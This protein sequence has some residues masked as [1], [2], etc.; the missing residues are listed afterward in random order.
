M[1]TCK[2]VTLLTQSTIIVIRSTHLFV[3][4]QVTASSVPLQT[5][6]IASFPVQT[7]TQTVMITPTAT[8]QRFIQNPLICHQNPSAAFQGKKKKN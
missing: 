4:F 3:S 6:T 7:Q 2:A 1:L 5:Q 8:Q